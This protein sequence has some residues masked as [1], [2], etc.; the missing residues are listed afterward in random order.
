MTVRRQ[1][2]KGRKG[3]RLCFLSRCFLYFLKRLDT[4]SNTHP[5]YLQKHSSVISKSS[6]CADWQTGRGEAWKVK[7]KKECDRVTAILAVHVD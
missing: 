1:S 7:N 5:L 3:M 6:L 4:H 2:I